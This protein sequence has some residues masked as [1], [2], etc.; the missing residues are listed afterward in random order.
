MHDAHGVPI[1]RDVRLEAEA[2]AAE[3]G[4]VYVDDREPGITRRKHGK[5]FRYLTPSGR[6]M[7]DPNTLDR[8]RALVIPPAWT[9]VWISAS[10]SGHI[11]ATG[12]DAKGRKQY[13]YHPDFRAIREETKFEKLFDF[14]SALPRIRAR[15]AEDLATPGLTREKVL[16]AVVSLLDLTLIRVGN[17]EYARLNES[18]GLTT[19]RKRHAKIKGATIELSFRGKSGVERT[20]R[21]V[22]R[23]IAALLKRCQGMKGEH[24]FRYRTA[25]GET[26]VVGSGDVNAYLRETS[27]DDFTAKDFRTWAGT[28]LAAVHLS[29][30]GAQETKTAVK[31]AAAEAIR[32]TAHKLGNTPTV[33]RKCYVHPAVLAA[34]EDGDVHTLP[35]E[36][37]KTLT[38]AELRPDER[39]VL[40]YLT[41]LTGKKLSTAER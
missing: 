3:A 5:G 2:S 29:E 41:K 38:R 22:D 19:L 37:A 23:R 12:R 34:F 18:F 13:R 24:L 26:A 27:G 1:A 4:L 6:P 7:R 30:L 14:A 9:S 8:I 17:E 20:V 32:K 21:V 36:E 16:A 40:A 33:C 31:R 11:Q 25:A 10:P 28:V 39:L 15:V 35:F